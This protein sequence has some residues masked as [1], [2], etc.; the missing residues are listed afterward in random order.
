MFLIK[1]VFKEKKLPFA[2]RYHDLETCTPF[3]NSKEMFNSTLQKNLT[4]DKYTVLKSKYDQLLKKYGLWN[5]L[6]Y[7]K[8]DKWLTINFTNGTKPNQ[9]RLLPPFENMKNFSLQIP[10]HQQA[11]VLGIRISSKFEGANNKVSK[12]VQMLKQEIPEESKFE[13]ML[14]SADEI[15]SSHDSTSGIRTNDLKFVSRDKAEKFNPNQGEP[16]YPCSNCGRCFVESSLR[17]HER[18]CA[19]VFNKSRRKFDN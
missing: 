16:T 8:S 10:P 11:C 6:G 19:R 1:I 14:L 7:N 4:D 3:N 12:S 5:L 13:D 17:K 18:I 15:D 9:I 2:A